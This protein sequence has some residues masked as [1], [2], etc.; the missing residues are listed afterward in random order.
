MRLNS[1][2]L[3]RSPTS[4]S[5]FWLKC[6]VSQELGL[7]MQASFLM[8]SEKLILSLIPFNILGTEFRS[9]FWSIYAVAKPLFRIWPLGHSIQRVTFNY[10]CRASNKEGAGAVIQTL[11]WGRGPVSPFFFGPSGLSWS[12]NKGG[13]GRTPRAPPLVPPLGYGYWSEGES[14][15]LKW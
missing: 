13:G 1:A 2:L 11:G 10:L 15:G 5:N 8:F 4:I 12:K 14:H 6:K 3:F 9:Q 7:R